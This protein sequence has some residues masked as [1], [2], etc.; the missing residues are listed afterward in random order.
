[1]MGK[2][3]QCAWA[4]RGWCDHCCS[5]YIPT[6]F[7]HKKQEEITSMFQS[8]ASWAQTTGFLFPCLSQLCPVSH[9]PVGLS[10]T[11]V[12]KLRMVCN[13]WSNWKVA[14]DSLPWISSIL[15]HLYLKKKKVVSLVLT[16]VTKPSF[17]EHVS[18]ILIAPYQHT[19]TYK[20]FKTC[21]HQGINYETRK[22]FVTSPK[23][24]SGC[25][26]ASWAFWIFKWLHSGLGSE[27]TIKLE[28]SCN[29][30]SDCL[31]EKLRE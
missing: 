25:L 17:R 23:M 31:L 3:S 24:N 8:A 9:Q 16:V 5:P 20:D 10:R 30:P 13:L 19:C 29:H 26:S 6:I 21:Q 18:K 14:L 15:Q 2:G 1:M 7:Q 22:D 12:R 27:S 28:L 11:Q 4:G